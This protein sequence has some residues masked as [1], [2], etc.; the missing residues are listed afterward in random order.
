MTPSRPKSAL[1]RGLPWLGGLVVLAYCVP[2]LSHP[3]R[4][5]HEADW[6]QYPARY[7]FARLSWLSGAAPLWCPYFGGGHFIAGDPDGQTLT[8]ITPLVLAFGEVVG[9]KLALVAAHVLAFTGMYC[10]MRTAW[11]VPRLPAVYAALL[12]SLSGWLPGR[13]YQGNWPEIYYAAAPWLAVLCLRAKRRPRYAIALGLAL[14]LILPQA[15]Q[16]LASLVLFV[17]VFGG[18]CGLRLP[19]VKLDVVWVVPLACAVALLVG[20]VKLAPTLDLFRHGLPLQAGRDLYAPHDG[21]ITALHWTRFVSGAVSTEIDVLKHRSSEM[22]V[23]VVACVAAVLGLVVAWRRAWRVGLLTA[24]FAWLMM[25]WRAPVDLFQWLHALPVFRTMTNPVREFDFFFVFGLAALAG[26]ATARGWQR[27]RLRWLVAAVCAASVG[28]LLWANAAYHR[29]QFPH[30]PGPARVVADHLDSR[31]C[32]VQPRWAPRPQ[33][34]NAYF[35]LLRGVA[36]VNYHTSLALPEFAQPRHFVDRFGRL[37]PNSRYRGEAYVVGGEEHVLVHADEPN[38]LRLSVRLPE[39]GVVVVNQ[40]HHRGWAASSG[41]LIEQDGLLALRLPAGEHD[42]ELRFEAAAFWWGAALSLA[43]AAGALWLIASRAR[44]LLRA[45]AWL[46]L[47]TAKRLSLR[48]GTGA[49]VAFAAAGVLGLA[50]WPR[51][52]AERLV[53]KALAQMDRRDFALAADLL[54]EAARLRPRAAPLRRRLGESLVRAGK[55]DAGIR[56]LR[57]AVALAPG[58]PA[59]GIAL[60]RALVSEGHASDALD[61]LQGLAA[62]FPLLWKV[63]FWQA[64][65]ACALGD[66]DRADAGLCRAIELGLPDERMLTEFRPLKPLRS[67][68]TFRRLVQQVRDRQDP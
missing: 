17:A 28:E 55:P 65:C 66:L 33:E 27:P 23:G 22:C 53:A 35:N 38:R 57:E 48:P 49:A 31:A 13:V 60:A 32:L 6:L 64:V 61:V 67:R 30:E 62:R 51:V 34:G 5:S 1:D 63:P 4:V 21:V 26:L 36:T 41:T 42:V 12:L 8:L 59:N 18:V 20:A 29:H 7:L 56:A 54:A 10:L 3:Y 14:G 9:L 50:L 47:Q 68:P 39:P 52:Q 11:S 2:Y 46:R 44:W 43:A 16:S 45:Q 58:D 25:A 19:R 40:N 24:A 15:R 37:H